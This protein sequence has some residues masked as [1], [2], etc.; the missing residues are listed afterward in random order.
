MRRIEPE[1]GADTAR[2]NAFVNATA[3]ELA[4][5]VI[6]FI[7]VAVGLKKGVVMTAPFWS[8]GMTA[9][10]TRIFSVLDKTM[11]NVEGA[12]VS[13]WK[14][15]EYRASRRSPRAAREMRTHRSHPRGSAQH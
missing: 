15:E 14:V 5:E 10:E 13:A 8:P 7:P 9:S 6:R 12:E 11:V 2:G 4:V 1:T 3:T